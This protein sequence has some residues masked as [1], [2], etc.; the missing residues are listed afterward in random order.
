MELCDDGVFYSGDT[1]LKSFVDQ[2][3]PVES[4]FDDVVLPS[5]EKYPLA[6]EPVRDGTVKL[7]NRS[8]DEY[9]KEKF[10][11]ATG[12]TDWDK[13]YE[14]GIENLIPARAVG[15]L[16]G[17]S[18]SGKTFLAIELVGA[19]VTGR[20]AF[21]KFEVKRMGG[22]LYIAVEGRQG[23]AHRFEAYRSARNISV[24]QWNNSVIHSDQP[25]DFHTTPSEDMVEYIAMIEAEHKMKIQLVIIDTYVSYSGVQNENSA[26]DNQLANA[27]MR[28]VS[29]RADCSVMAIHHSGKSGTSNEIRPGDKF[30]RILR[31]SSDQGASAEFVLGVAM[32]KTTSG[33]VVPWVWQAKLKDVP[34]CE[35][36][37][38]PIETYYLQI[39]GHLPQ[40]VGVVST[41]APEGIELVVRS[42]HS[43][44]EVKKVGR[45][46]KSYG[47]ADYLSRLILKSE[48][49]V[50]KT[51]LRKELNRHLEA[52]GVDIGSSRK[53][54]TDR[55]IKTLNECL[56]E[57]EVHYLE[58]TQQYFKNAR[59]HPKSGG[60][61]GSKPQNP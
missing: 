6:D 8:R 27:W 57:H 37:P 10:G 11:Y 48:V 33:L 20:A 60:E 52:Q 3:I 34:V 2:E 30:D 17:P 55:A 1:Q 25:F 31:G 59:Y 61:S 7:K 46:S 54:R 15:M 14:W 41:K 28:K 50:N 4:Y 23:L 18:A 24:E 44:A 21:G 16:G 12:S 42:G 36:I 13:P 58:N 40:P 51:N 45:P 53:S 32:A 38:A 9:L 39:D 5:D 22:V 19:T 49:P 26:R 56:V 35:P 47:D 29:T 43:S